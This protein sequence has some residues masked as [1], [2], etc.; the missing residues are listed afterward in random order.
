MSLSMIMER[1]EKIKSDVWKHIG[2]T[3]CIIQFSLLF[4]TAFILLF[5][6]ETAELQQAGHRDPERVLLLTS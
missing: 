2:T 5:Q 3:L 1:K 6:T 4:S